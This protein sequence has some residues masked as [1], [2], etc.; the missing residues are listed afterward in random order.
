MS[1]CP[2]ASQVAVVV[3]NLPASAGDIRDAGS[4]PGLGRS[5]GGGHGNPLQY[6]CL[7][8]PH[9]RRGW[10][11]VVHGVAQSQTRPC[12]HSI[13]LRES[14]KYAPL[15]QTLPGC[16]VGKG[17]VRSTLENSPVCS[18]TNHNSSVI[19]TSSAEA[20]E[21]ILHVSYLSTPCL[22]S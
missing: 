13:P 3:E 19:V 2:W 1:P 12:V 20:G 7:E 15:D 22:L 8:N 11:A 14:R 10:W 6:A 18:S 16:K 21:C 9:D 17:E 4:I 5:P